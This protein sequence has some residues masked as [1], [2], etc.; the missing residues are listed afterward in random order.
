[1]ELADQ[2][3]ARD[4]VQAEW[5]RISLTNDSYGP[6]Y[7]VLHTG[8]DLQLGDQARRGAPG[9][10]GRATDPGQ[11]PM[12]SNGIVGTLPKRSPKR[13]SLVVR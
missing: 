9:V 4:V 11:T 3:C 13:V 8:K 7:N 6:F 1:M 10:S 5:F 2:S 12:I